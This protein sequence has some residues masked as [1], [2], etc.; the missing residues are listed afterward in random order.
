MNQFYNHPEIDDIYRD[1]L[2]FN[3]VEPPAGAWA[4]IEKALQKKV[5]PTKTALSLIAG[6]ASM[7]ILLITSLL[8]TQKKSN[9]VLNE[10]AL[11]INQAPIAKAYNEATGLL[12]LQQLHIKPIEKQIPVQYVPDEVIITEHS[13]ARH[14]IQL[15]PAK[16]SSNLVLQDE[17]KPLIASRDILII[18][19]KQVIHFERKSWT[20]KYLNSKM[21]FKKGLQ[22][23]MV[24]NFNNTWVLQKIMPETTNTFSRSFPSPY[25]SKPNYRAKFG[26][27]WG[28]HIGYELS[29]HSSVDA[30]VLFNAREGQKYAYDSPAGSITKLAELNYTRIPIMYRYRMN[31]PYSF[32]RKVPATVSYLVGV[33]YGSLRHVNIDSN[34]QFLNA[35]N[36]NTNEWGLVL[37]MEYDFYLTHHYSLTIGSRASMSKGLQSFPFF[38][39]QE[40]TAP[41][42]TFL[43]LTARFNYHFGK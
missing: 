14:V 9:Y 16:P 43:G 22:I 6:I 30:E 34:I 26:T 36:F 3:P 24:G 7:I 17:S 27:S 15:K 1:A 25:D 33:Q 37:G 4:D 8:T 19:A 2:K 29:K 38:V 23:G 12:A 20:A 40:S 28:L 21:T 13:Q 35:D 39:N 10:L 18:T 11:T 31:S 5:Y 41:I 32:S 42:N